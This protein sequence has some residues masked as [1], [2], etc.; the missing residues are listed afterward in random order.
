MDVGEEI[1][2]YLVIE[3]IGRGGMADVWSARDRRLNRMVAIKTIAHGLSP[4]VDPVAL[5]EKEAR[6][7]ARIEHPHILPIYDFGEFQGQLY[8]VMRYVTGGSL[9]DVLERG[10]LPVEDVLRKGEAIAKALDHAHENQIIHLDLKPPNI[11]LDSNSSPYLADF[12]LATVLDREG[13]A[14]NPGSGTLLYMAPEQLTAEVIDHKADIYSFGIMMFHMLTGKLPFDAI[15]PLALKQLQFHEELPSVEEYHEDLPYTLTDILRQATAVEPNRRPDHLMRIVDEMR[16]ALALSS[17]YSIAAG[18]ALSDRYDDT[19]YSGQVLS[20]ED[21]G[22]LEAVDLYSRAR[23]AWA[24]GNGRFLLGVTHFML[25]SG[26]YMDAATHGLELDQYGKQMLLRG[27]L[28][29]DHEMDYWWGRVDDADRRW[30]CLHTIR[31]ENAGARIRALYRLETL[32]DD[33]TKPQIVKLVAQALDVE[34]NADAR[35]A[36]LR[37]LGTRSQLVKPKQQ[38]DIETV[39][40]GRLLT[41]MTRIALQIA[42]ESQWHNVVY[43]PEVDVL[44]AETALDLG[45][46][47]VAQFAA[48][49]VGRMRSVAAVQHIADAQREGR[50]GAL[51]ALALVRD[52]APNLPHVVS[53]QGRLYA[54]MANTVRRLTDRPLQMILRFVLALFGGWIAMGENVFITFRSNALFTPQ[55]SANTVAF[56]LVFALMVGMLVIVADEFSERLR[57]FWP[58]WTRLLVMGTLGFLMGMLTWVAYT[59]FFNQYSPI[60]EYVRFGGFGIAFGFILTATFNLRGWQAFTV[61]ALS[62]FLPLYAVFYNFCQQ[63][64]LCFTPEGNPIANF[65]FTPVVGIGLATG[66]ILGLLARSRTSEVQTLRLQLPSWAG[67]ILS[68]LL[69]FAFGVITWYGYALIFESQMVNWDG[70]LAMFVIAMFVSF[71]ASYFL[72]AVNRLSF[73]L[74]SAASYFVLYGLLS[75]M[76]Q[77]VLVVPSADSILFYDDGHQILTVGLPLA[78]AIA[79]GGHAQKIYQDLRGWIGVAKE[80]DRTGWLTGLLVYCT[81]IGGIVG[82]FSMFSA[83]TNLGWAI[84]WTIWGALTVIF[85]LAAREWRKW[86][87]VGLILSALFLMM[88]TLVYDFVLASFIFRSPEPQPFMIVSGIWVL[89]AVALGVVTWGAWQR[90]L[91]AGIGLVAIIASWLILVIFQDMPDNFFVFGAANFALVIYALAPSWSLF[92]QVPLKRQRVASILT[93]DPTA[94]T[95]PAPMPVRPT[96]AAVMSMQ[97]EVDAGA[98]SPG[99]MRTELEPGA[100]RAF[101]KT[102]IDAAAEHGLDMTE[103][104]VAAKLEYGKTEIDPAARHGI[105]LGT[106][107][108]L[109]DT[110]LDV[111]SEV[112]EDD[113]SG[114][115]PDLDT[116][117]DIAKRPTQIAPHHEGEPTRAGETE[118]DVVWSADDDQQTVI[119]I[120][121]QLASKLPSSTQPH[122]DHEQT[123]SPP[124]GP[125]MTE[126]DARSRYAS[127]PSD[128][129]MNIVWNVKDDDEEDDD[130]DET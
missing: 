11:L 95:V 85:A 129:E 123:E 96:P 122:G 10:P 42:P 104:D 54:W 51:R 5:F 2:Q 80:H 76:F 35:I 117:E 49:T 63:V 53:R 79:L 37:V 23:H 77:Q 48:R 119:G 98:Y 27:A 100:E 130:S 62:T 46:P 78:I 97:T 41:S 128:T 71:I 9:E 118:M 113:D 114:W 15:A 87:A 99:D 56:G 110:V 75:N 115:K 66:L 92:G 4:D 103:I 58:W 94:P 26:Y 31:S 32:P 8:I 43:S 88:G 20:S 121:D 109:Y 89:W 108:D 73:I 7:I 28:E 22:L 47:Q 30:V 55:R 101:P 65:N 16:D 105:N 67:V 6:T 59:W 124:S 50:P 93:A 25:M 126:I 33:P 13:R 45:M 18:D 60:W 84:V 107:S 64:F 3:H 83:H 120:K 21:S 86:G 74:T 61:T 14:T 57:G 106:N 82:I 29:Y 12:G 44:V 116:E 52:E 125:E 17:G 72:N 81:A 19:F 24:G 34:T 102:E 1:N 127:P 36:A 39:F 111:G 68:G 70:I 90:R 91:W 38:Y 69:G 112:E 40:R